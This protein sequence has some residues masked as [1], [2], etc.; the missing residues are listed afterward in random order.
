VSLAVD[1]TASSPNHGPR[2]TGPVDILLLHYTAMASAAAARDWL[3][4]PASKVSAHYLVDEAGGVFALVPEERRA[5]HAGHAAWAG[6]R[7]VNSRS[8]GVELQ[9]L[10]HDGG[11]PAYPEA[12]IAA[13]IELSRGILARHPIPPH[14]VLAH[15]DVAPARK[16]DPGEWFPWARLA[17]AGIGLWPDP[18]PP[19]DDAMG[20]GA[21]GYAVAALRH[22]LASFG[23]GLGV[24]PSYDAETTCVVRAFQR[25]FRPRR[26]DG[27]A[28]RSTRGA[29]ARLLQTVS[30]G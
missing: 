19:D 28:D 7:D 11:A 12:Q 15:S 3:C 6:E 21:E 25:H 10:G 29:L 1:A 2:R 9:N 8:I 27:R 18:P 24:S 30:Q 23:Y 22:D 17:R 20:E 26:V 4:N 14:R 13:L 5:W 16:I